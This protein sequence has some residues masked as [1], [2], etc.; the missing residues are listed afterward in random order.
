MVTF[1]QSS[2]VVLIDGLIRRLSHSSSFT[3]SKSIEQKK[4]PCPRHAHKSTEGIG[5]STIKV[6]QEKKKAG[7]AREVLSVRRAGGSG[8]LQV[9]GSH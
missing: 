3:A 5:P 4:A 8:S 2:R 7:R 9:G 6:E 1:S